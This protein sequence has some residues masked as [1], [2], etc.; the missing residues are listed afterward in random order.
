MGEGKNRAG[1]K[2]NEYMNEMKLRILKHS[3]GMICFLLFKPFE[4]LVCR[5]SACIR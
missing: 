2:N 4:L 3:C 5:Y 1:T